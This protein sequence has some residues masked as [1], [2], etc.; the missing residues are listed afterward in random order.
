[1]KLNNGALGWI[2][3]MLLDAWICSAQA[4]A[5]NDVGKP[6]RDSLVAPR[7]YPRR[8]IQELTIGIGCQPAQAYQ[9]VQP[10]STTRLTPVI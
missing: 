9:A 7:K 6:G 5:V 4:N 3:V 8:P 2:A 10:P 1:M